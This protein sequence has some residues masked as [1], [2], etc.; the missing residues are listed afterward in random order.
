MTSATSPSPS[1]I[2]THVHFFDLDGDLPLQWGWLE[3]PAPGDA[4]LFDDLTNVRTR[5]FTSTEL[6]HEGRRLGGLR[7]CVHVQS[8]LGSSDPLEETRWVHDLHAEHGLPGGHIAQ[9]PMASDE[10]ASLVDQHRSY[11]LTRGVRD[12]GSNGELLS[13]T[14]VANVRRLGHHDLLFEV[15]CSPRRY[16]DLGALAEQAP[17]T[18]LVL[19]HF[20]LPA[21]YSEEARK[22]W[23]RGLHQLASRDNIWLKLSG[24]G[25]VDHDWTWQGAGRLVADALE[26]FGTQRCVV[27]SNW[28]ID[29]SVSSYPDVVRAITQDL[30]EAE[31]RAVLY[32]NAI[33]LYSPTLRDNS[34]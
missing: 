28:P 10:A 15:F 8:A 31:E 18:R 27:G 1:F 11:D 16:A 7:Q 17:D 21:G 32:D 34:P 25:L 5:R 3:E 26:A 12:P 6:L 23:R 4:V 22:V 29:R 30:S 9:V 2:D 14:Y 33:E 24:L 20:G 13:P 19:E